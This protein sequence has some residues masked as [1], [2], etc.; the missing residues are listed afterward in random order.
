MP[1]VQFD[2]P[3]LA[4]LYDHMCGWSPDRD[5]YLEAAGAE[6]IDILD[7]GCGTGLICDAY[8]KRGHKVTGA[9]PSKAMLEVAQNQ[10]NGAAIEWVLTEAESFSSAKRFDL[11]IMTGHAF[12]VLLDDDATRRVF[13]VMADYLKSSGQIIFESRNPALDWPAIWTKANQPSTLP[14]GGT[15]AWKFIKKS[16][17]F[18]T[19]EHHYAF[20]NE[21]LISRSTLRFPSKT[22]IEALLKLSGLR[23]QS[24]LGDWDG[25]SFDENT[26]PEMIFRVSHDQN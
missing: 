4:A 20:S 8:A 26:S 21:T 14:G 1:D 5:F 9:D 17:E 3:R 15:H 10:P 19:F 13:R 24:V 7:L 6:P 25:S 18:I 12:Q 11:I 16:D 22:G 2:H 23:V